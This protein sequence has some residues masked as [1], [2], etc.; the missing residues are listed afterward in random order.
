MSL[1]S[2]LDSPLDPGTIREDG[3]V[4][5]KIPS[6][7]LLTGRYFVNVY[8]VDS[9][10]THVYDEIEHGLTLNV[11]GEPKRGID[12]YFDIAGEWTLRRESEAGR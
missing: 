5:F 1:K 7:P 10:S 11:R 12:G 6:L 9:H 2:T 3:V 4:E 8:A